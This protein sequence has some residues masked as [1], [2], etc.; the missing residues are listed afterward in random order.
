MTIPND[1]EHLT[2]WLRDPQRVKPGNKMPELQ[3]SPSDLAA[4]VAY[5]EEL[6]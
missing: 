3:L 5:L 4:L 1:R 6:K 2:G